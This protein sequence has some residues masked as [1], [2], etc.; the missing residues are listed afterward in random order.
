M[1]AGDEVVVRAR[2]PSLLELR[3]ERRE[4]VLPAPD[5][6]RPGNRRDAES[7]ERGAENPTSPPHARRNT[8]RGAHVL[9]GFRHAGTDF[10]QLQNKNDVI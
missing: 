5:D 10:L 7:D 4:R 3:V 1:V 8:L 2:E 6:E 9:A